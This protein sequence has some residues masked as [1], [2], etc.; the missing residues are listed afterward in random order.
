MI[1]TNRIDRSRAAASMDHQRSRLI[2]VPLRVY[3]HVN[4][5]GAAPFFDLGNPIIV[6]KDQ[7]QVQEVR[8]LSEAKAQTV[9]LDPERTAADARRK[10]ANSVKGQRALT[11]YALSMLASCPAESDPKALDPPTD[12]EKAIKRLTS[13]QHGKDFSAA[14]GGLDD[15][16]PETQVSDRRGSGVPGLSLMDDDGSQTCKGAVEILSRNSQKG[17]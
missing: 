13:G 16:F 17:K 14:V 7:S 12:L 3:N 1:G 10:Q 8:P 15:E 4:I 6:L 11:R 9:P 5:T 2:K